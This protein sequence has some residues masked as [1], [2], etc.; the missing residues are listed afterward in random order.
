MATHMVIWDNVITDNGNIN[1]TG[2]QDVHGIAVNGTRV[3]I[4]DN[5]IARSSGD[6]VQVHGQQYIYI[7]RNRSHHNKQ[8]GLWTKQAAD[9]IFSQNIVYGHRPSSSASGAGMGGQY[10]QERVWFLFNESYDNAIG[11]AIASSRDGSYVG[12]FIG[13]VVHDNRGPG[14]SLWDMERHV[15]GNTVWRNGSGIDSGGFF[16]GSGKPLHLVNNIIGARIDP[17]GFDI[18]IKDP[19]MAVESEMHHNIVFGAPE[20]IAWGNT[21]PGQTLAHLRASGAKGRECSNSDPLLTPDGTPGLGSFAID[22]GI[23]HAAYATF[24][25]LYGIDIRN[26]FALRPRPRGA[27]WDIGAFESGTDATGRG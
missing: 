22:R 9:V 24:R 25:S 18:Y 4:V 26:D 14:M 17:S 15:V 16:R 7:G 3:W 12:Y 21:G 1:D 6:G 19:V 5:E 2:D 10:G 11:M 20:R 23:E 8:T 13:N 27:G